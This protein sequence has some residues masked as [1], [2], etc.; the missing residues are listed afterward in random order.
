MN[1]NNFHYVAVLLDM[2][3]GL[4]IDD[5]DLEELGLLAWDK[6]GNKNT[7]LY[8]YHACFGCDSDNSIALPCNAVSV[9][10]VTIPF[11]DWNI[12]SNKSDYGDFNS[13]IIETD[14]EA[15]KVFRNPYYIPGKLVSYEQSGDTLY[16]PKNYG[17]V[18]ILYK[19]IIADE[20]GLPELTDKEAHAIATYIAYVYKYKEGLKTNNTV[21]INLAANLEN[22]WLKQCDQARVT[23]LNQNDMNEILDIKNSWNRKNYSMSYKFVNR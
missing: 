18:N 5:E 11:E 21:M 19:G 20:D 23:G 2:L 14:I 3:Y 9:E 22:K 8:L 12:S 6:I 13:Q 10:A 4:E 16:F 1:K 17:S 7:R 15:Q